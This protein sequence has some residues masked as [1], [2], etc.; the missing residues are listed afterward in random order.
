M[1]RDRAWPP[2]SYEEHSWTPSV[3]FASRR[4]A[5]DRAR[6]YRAAVPL[7][8]ANRRV[9]L[10]GEA[11][12]LAA[13]ATAEI[14]RFDGEIGSDLAPFGALLLRSESAASSQIENLTA[15]AKAV[16]LAEAGDTSRVN[17]SLIAANTDAMQAALAMS[18]RIDGD[19]IIAMQSALLGSS[20]PRLV[21]A[22][23]SEQ[24]WIGGRA[25]SPH[26]ASFVPPHHDQVPE[27]IDDLVH[28][29]HRTD[30]P[31]FVL[32]M[33]GHAQFETIH[34]FPDGN[35]RTGR[36]LIHAILRWTRVT[37]RVT[38]PVSAGLLSDTGAYFSALDAYRAGDLDPIITIA[39][40]ATFHALANA[41]LLASEVSHIR[42]EW[43]EQLAGTRADSVAWQ[44]LGILHASPVIDAKLI[45]DRFG[46]SAPTA[47]DAINRLTE[48]GI[49]VRA[50]AG[51]RNRKWIAPRIPEALDRFA[52]RSGRRNL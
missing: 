43:S 41:R 51:P 49:V 16:L 35:G 21:G 50:N 2:L 36:A 52:E 4:D 33:I 45:V 13:E 47:S 23:R 40:D 32:A 24:V 17:A 38:V 8:I 7:K 26:G 19:S 9:D 31:P 28:F 18:D 37:T 42:T 20:N 30:V 12:A 11:E 22:F 27:A 14:S 46:V 5:F 1:E 6:P 3:A 25:S 48:Q 29:F 44:V 10:T 34:P 39:A 15:S